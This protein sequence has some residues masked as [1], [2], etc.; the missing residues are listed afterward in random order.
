MKA[1]NIDLTTS[2]QRLPSHRVSD[3]DFIA[4]VD[5]VGVV[6]ITMAQD[7]NTIIDKLSA[8]DSFTRASAFQLDEL[9]AKSSSS[10]DLL[11]I[12]W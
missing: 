5:N 12:R 8:G 6:E 11:L 9:Q 3:V 2:H 4:D 1:V 10:G 7:E